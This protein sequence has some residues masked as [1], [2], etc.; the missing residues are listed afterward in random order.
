MSKSS[1]VTL[2]TL[3]FTASK[4]KRPTCPVV[5]ANEMYRDF[6][7][8][9]LPDT[10]MDTAYEMLINPKLHAMGMFP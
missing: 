4:K 8:V 9:L 7:G 6:L 5:N 3:Q 1:T 10:I 2:N